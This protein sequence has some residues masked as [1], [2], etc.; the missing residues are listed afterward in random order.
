MYFP[1]V[2]D[3]PLFALYHIGRLAEMV[4]LIIATCLFPDHIADIRK[5]IFLAGIALLS[6]EAFELS[7]WFGRCGQAAAGH[8][9]VLGMWSIDS[10]KWWTVIHAGRIISGTTLCC[11]RGLN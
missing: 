1:N 8:E 7:Y 10:V 2:R 4:F 9:N 5:M 11:V 3:H 6:W